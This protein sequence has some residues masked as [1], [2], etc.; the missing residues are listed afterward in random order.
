[1]KP[2]K[3]VVFCIGCQRPKMLFESQSKAD[4]FMKYNS[5]AILEEN[6]KAPVRSYYC[7]FCCGYHV[8]SDPSPTHGQKLNKRDKSLQD[9]LVNNFKKNEEF[10]KLQESIRKRLEAS[11]RMIKMGKVEEAEDLL[12]ACELYLTEQ[13]GK[14]FSLK[15]R[16]KLTSLYGRIDALR[17]ILPQLREILNLPFEQQLSFIADETDDSKSEIRGKVANIILERDVMPIVDDNDKLIDKNQLEGIT[18]RIAYCLEIL[19]S[20]KTAKKKKKI[21]TIEGRLFNQSQ[22]VKKKTTNLMN[23]KTAAVTG[24]SCDHDN[25]KSSHPETKEKPKGCILP[26][27]YKATLTTLIK[28][29]ELIAQAYEKKDYE[30]CEVLID[31]TNAIIAE[32][33]VDDDNI[34]LIRSNLDRWN[35]IILG[36]GH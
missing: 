17:R 7:E 21:T 9:K 10:L 4:N 16:A 6:G 24:E 15:E 25:S 30:E 3:N 20:I 28:K 35:D 12:D 5:D 34:R 23:Q 31:V 32:L 26:A 2:T 27:Y 29:L 1:M 33:D 11:K 19:K 13:D 8:T 18:E 22:L 14:N 36:T